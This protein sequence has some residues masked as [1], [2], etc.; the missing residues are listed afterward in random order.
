MT[1]NTGV[2][3]L[4]KKLGTFETNHRKSDVPI[5]KSL[6]IHSVVFGLKH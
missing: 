2:I 6:N 5:Q 1:G 4:K 3:S